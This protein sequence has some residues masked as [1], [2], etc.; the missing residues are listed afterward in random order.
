MAHP[1]QHILNAFNIPWVVVGPT[2]I[3]ISFTFDGSSSPSKAPG[4]A[5]AQLTYMNKTAVIDA[6]MTD[7]SDA[8]IFSAHTVLRK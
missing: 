7:D 3:F 5:E 1:T 6:V 4:E 2:G 8:F